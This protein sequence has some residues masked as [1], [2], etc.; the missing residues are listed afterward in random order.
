MVEG[1]YQVTLALELYEGAEWVCPVLKCLIGRLM[2]KTE[3]NEGSN[4]MAYKIG[5]RKFKNEIDTNRNKM[6]RMFPLQRL[7][8]GADE[9]RSADPAEMDAE[10]ELRKKR[11]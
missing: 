8:I 4:A 7:G 10:G 1:I 6:V 2:R 9:D 5:K 3:K 11:G